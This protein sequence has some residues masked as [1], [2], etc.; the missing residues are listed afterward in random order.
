MKVIVDANI[1]F[2]AILN[3]NSKIGYLILNSEGI[4]DFIAP[5][6]LDFEIKK[7]HSKIQ[8]ITGKSAAEI[9]KIHFKIMTNISFVSEEQIQRK[10]WLKAYDIVNDIDPKDTPY[11]AF[12]DYLK[13]K[14][15]TGDKKLSRG[16]INK[17]YKHNNYCK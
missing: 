10:N 17:G 5:L 14:I 2:S 6:Y 7:Y 4:I 3:T 1:V 15:W 13:L 8:K 11:V 16:L 9:S 12:S